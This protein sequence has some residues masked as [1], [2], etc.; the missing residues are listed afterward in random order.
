MGNFFASLAFASAFVSMISLFLAEREKGQEKKS[1]ERLGF[2]SFGLH[3]VSIVGIIATLFYLIYTHQYQFHYVWSHSSNELPVHYMISCFWEGQEGSF[4]LWCFWHAVLGVILMRTIKSEWK[5]LV[6]GVVA[7]VEVILSSMIL[8]IY[9]GGSWVYGIYILMGLVPLGYLAI[10]YAKSYFPLHSQGEM[11]SLLA[12][13]GSLIIVPF[14][15]TKAFSW[16]I[17]FAVSEEP[18]FLLLYVIFSLATAYFMLTYFDKKRVNP[19]KGEDNSIL[20]Q[21]NFILSTLIIG[22]GSLVILFKGDTNYF[23]E[24]FARDIFAEGISFDWLVFGFLQSWMPVAFYFLLASTYKQ[25]GYG[26]RIQV[27]EILA[28]MVVLAFA[29][30]AGSFDVSTWKIGS[31]PFLLLKEA[32][33]NNPVYA[34]NPDFVPTNGSGLN[35]LLQ[36]YWMVIHPPTLFL[37]FASTVVPFAFVIAGLIKGKYREWIRP[38]TP[39]MLFSVMILGIGIIMGGYWAYE[40][41]N[42]GGYWNWDPVENGS[43]VPWIC[44]IA[45]LHG[46]LIHQK[47]KSYLK[48]TMIL[49]IFT[50]GLVLYSTF[51]TRSG[52]LGDTSVHTFTDLGLSGQLVLLMAVYGVLTM[53]LMV[54]RWKKIPTKVDE[55]KIW[56]AQFFL[57]MGILVFIFSGLIIAISTSLP[58]FNKIFGTSMAPPAEVQL[59]YYKWNVWF[60]VAIGIFSG[61]AQFL[62]WSKA[63]KKTAAQALY[64]PF[65]IA[66]LIG[67]GIL[68]LLITGRKEFAYDPEFSELLASTEFASG[69]L[70][71]IFRYLEFGVMSIADEM[72]LFSS[73]FI[74]FANGDIMLS[75]LRKNKSGLKVIGG[76]VTHI[77]F[78]L[79]LIGM[80]FSSGYDEVISINLTP[81]EMQGFTDEEEKVDNVG[82]L[83]RK[84]RKIK[85]YEVTYT[86]PKE[87]AAPIRK[88]H[89]I[90]ETPEFFKVRFRDSTGDQFGF[91]LP[92]P[93]FLLKEEGEKAH[94]TNKV[95]NS[96][97]ELEGTID[98]EYVE[99]FLN[100]NIALIKPPHINNRKLYGLE[101]QSLD[102]PSDQFKLYPE[103]EVN[104]QMNGIIAHPARRIYWDKDIY[105]HVSQIPAN[106]GEEPKYKIHDL[107]LKP[108]DT[109]FIGDTKIYFH[110]I[111][112]L[113]DRTEMGD[114][115]E[116][117]LAAHMLAIVEQDTFFANPMYFIAKDNSFSMKEASIDELHLDFAF[118]KVD[119]KKGLFHF[120]IRELENPTSDYIAFK[121][122]KKPYINLL[123]LGTFV[124]TFGFLIA[125]Y[126]RIGENR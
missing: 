93:V 3:A 91:V 74:I 51:L 108:G 12:L 43:L 117:A 122:I 119:P 33:P 88:L 7:S 15:L 57:F 97:E 17:E 87:A 81:E 47:T 71:K 70:D 13:W 62:W 20:Y 126:R 48:L 59:F 103:A 90:E 73:L 18:P 84:P 116:V 77:G 9:V 4:L 19:T 41:L 68:V 54:L 104:G 94:T 10:R 102:K 115:F 27:G 72:L 50:F 2:A 76:A 96:K 60:A 85:G 110:N 120:Q 121:A 5:G 16:L 22:L 83:R 105:V 75:L 56:S 55:S 25:G 82:I 39:W 114:N 109:T 1:W 107:A 89:V 66:M 63:K 44:G 98:M 123:W 61:I 106:E 31:S 32:F 35:S 14:A 65:L 99:T 28:G 34:S 40:T 8:G 36:N 52:I 78:G 125:I 46:M 30:V 86:G 45:G 80:L 100:N 38:S 24:L 21:G 29:I 37:G 11:T 79:M 58:V 23:A 69:F 124:L 53:V 64:R 42:F 101:F 26:K 49:V 118:F 111:A 113:A 92:R 95:S 112:N 67:T 6:L